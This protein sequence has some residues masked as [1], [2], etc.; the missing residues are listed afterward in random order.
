MSR[1][2]LA[3]FFGLLLGVATR[4]AMGHDHPPPQTC[5][6]WCDD[7]QCRCVDACN[8]LVPPAPQSCYRDC[9][10]RK[11]ECHAWC[12]LQPDAAGGAAV[13]EAEDMRLVAAESVSDALL[14]VRYEAAKR[15]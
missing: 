1:L 14:P 10:D 5:E 12:R 4:M 2:L 9:Y 3:V 7:T 11:M 8:K 15:E 6:Q 13:S